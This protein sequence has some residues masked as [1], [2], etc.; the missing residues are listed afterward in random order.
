MKWLPRLQYERRR[1][2]EKS[3][4]IKWEGGKCPVDDET[5][6]QV[7]FRDQTTYSSTNGGFRWNHIGA[8]GDIVAYRVV[9]E[10]TKTISPED[11][12]PTLWNAYKDV[13]NDEALS[14]L[15]HVILD[16]A[17]HER[18]NFVD[19]EYIVDAFAWDGTKYGVTF[20]EGVDMGEYDKNVAD[21]QVSDEVG[22]PAQ[23]D[24]GSAATSKHYNAQAIQ[25]IELMEMSFSKEEFKGFLK[26]NILKYS[27]RAGSKS[28]ESVFKDTVKAK[29]YRM[30]LDLVE[31]GI[32]IDPRVHV[33]IKGD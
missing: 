7:M 22:E 16:T 12:S 31:Q 33:V 3:E 15:R 1:N 32:K 2:V 26:G 19:E 25:P 8:L 10:V 24:I 5:G 21:R 30:W 4:W 9:K 14:A 13:L 17:N 20:W 29:Q 11:I 28:G 27:M 23:E 6:I 18:I